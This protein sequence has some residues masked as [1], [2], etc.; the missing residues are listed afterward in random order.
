MNVTVPDTVT[1]V[2]ALCC[3]NECIVTVGIDAFEGYVLAILV[4]PFVC[5]LL[6]TNV[7]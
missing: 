3:P 2:L 5:G 4:E 1:D 6:I 7:R